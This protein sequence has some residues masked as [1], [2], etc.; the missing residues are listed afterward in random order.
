MIWERQLPLIE[1]LGQSK[2]VLVY[3]ESY[4]RED[5]DNTSFRQKF[6]YFF[7]ANSFIYKRQQRTLNCTEQGGSDMLDDSNFLTKSEI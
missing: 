6:D 3:N 1:T 7:P 2:S 4:N 5:F